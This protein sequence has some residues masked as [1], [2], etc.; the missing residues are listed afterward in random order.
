MPT[1]LVTRKL[2]AN[3]LVDR[4]RDCADA[5][6]DVLAGASELPN[7]C[8]ASVRILGHTSAAVMG[9]LR[10]IWNGARLS[11]LGVPAPDL[12]KQ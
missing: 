5:Q 9:A 2:P 10:L 8:G 1:I 11:L 3:A 6:P 4:L 12:R 7:G